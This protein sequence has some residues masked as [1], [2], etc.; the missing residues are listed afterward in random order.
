MTT[1]DDTTT[2]RLNGRGGLLA[3]IPAMLGFHPQ[4]SLV[5]VCLSGPRRRVGPVIRV[6]LTDPTDSVAGRAGTVQRLQSHADR[7]SEEVA[8]VCYTEHSARPRLFQDLLAAFAASGRTVLDAVTVR[9]GRLFTFTGS[10]R[11]PAVAEQDGRCGA[12]PDANDRQVLAMSAATVFNGRGI[13]ADRQALRDSIAGPTGVAGERASA[14]LHAAAA[15]LLGQVGPAGPID[16]NRFSQM[17][18]LN[19][20]RALTEVAGSGT[21]APPLCA[22]ISLLL[23]DIEIRDDL[24][25]R[26]VTDPV[27]PWLPMLIAV[28]RATPDVDAAEV[29]AVLAV[30]AYRHGDGALA[31]VAVDRCLASEPHHRLA[32][33][34]MGVMDAGMPPENLVGLAGNTAARKG[35]VE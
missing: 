25:G 7:H 18:T 13:L 9:G 15:G 33:L 8:L 17:A 28:A 5:M 23:C 20:E 19:I 2:V 16:R 4:E 30:A 11:L 1:T 35:K 14:A 32:H 3:A 22:L 12:P 29:C 6:D 27:P 34:M 10:G 26:T 21:V 31:Q 24:I